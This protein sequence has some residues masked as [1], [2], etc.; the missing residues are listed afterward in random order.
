MGFE[1][2]VLESGWGSGAGQLGSEG[3]WV[4]GGKSRK[5]APNWRDSLREAWILG[6]KEIL[7]GK[8]SVVWGSGVVPQGEEGAMLDQGSGVRLGKG[9]DICRILIPG[10]GPH[11]ESGASK[12]VWGEA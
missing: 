4:P 7:Q 3:I 2:H 8:E 12:S 5:P 10:R 6:R 11:L 1:S 9:R